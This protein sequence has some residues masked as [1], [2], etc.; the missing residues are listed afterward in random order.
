MRAALLVS[1]WLLTA[2]SALAQP[3]SAYELT[4]KAAQHLSTIPEL[5][6]SRIRYFSAQD[7]P[8]ALQPALRS[9]LFFA[10]NSLHTRPHIALPRLVPG[11]R[12]QL[13]WFDLTWYGWSPEVWEFIAGKEPYF[14]EPIVPSWGEGYNF[15]KAYTHSQRPIVRASWFI[16]Y[17][18]D[19]TLNLDAKS[20][21]DDNAFYY[22]LVFGKKKIQVPV[23]KKVTKQVQVPVTEY[24]LVRYGNYYQQQPVTRYVTQT[25][26]E[27]VTEYQTKIVSAAPKTAREFEDFFRLDFTALKDFPI[28]IGAAI[29]E[30]KSGV[31]YRNR[32]LWRIRGSLGTYWRT[33]DVL[34]SV[35]QQDLLQNPFPEKFDAGEHIFQDDK[36]AQF[37]MLSD[38]DGKRV[39]FA[40]PRL[41]SGAGIGHPA[42]LNA[43]GCII[44]H[45]QG[46]LRF[47]NEHVRLNQLGIRFFS[48]SYPQAE[49]F[50]QFFVTNRIEH[51]IGRD[52]DE[53]AQF[54]RACNG[55]TP[56]ENAKQL[57]SL[58][59][60]YEQS[61]DLP[62][63]A[64]EV[65]C[66]P[67]ELRE[68]LGLGIGHPAAPAGTVNA[69]LAQLALESGSVPR[70]SWEQELY[71]EAALLVLER[72]KRLLLHTPQVP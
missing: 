64:R 67:L 1:C 42:V 30:A 24:Q 65:G 32:V 61:L 33:F 15:L 34:R 41:V 28:D 4:E 46:I 11:S 37:Y 57:A 14:I 40:D 9:S 21:Q 69:R 35:R 13:Y 39:E 49:R 25:Q 71:R 55:L 18:L 5:F 56:A 54:V 63:A 36:G 3:H 29:D 7:V 6:R 60:F 52:Q 44:C 22:L 38:G 72:R 53:Y 59:R 23:R 20:N 26:E 48:A 62:Q 51:W 43:I 68:A 19:T 2:G 66:S 16:H 8:D 70:Y 27:T 10:C 45:D 47:K 50:R 58:K 17:A 12:Q 31:S